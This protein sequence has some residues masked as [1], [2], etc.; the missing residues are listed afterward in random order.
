MENYQGSCKVQ[1]LGSYL[2]GG[3]VLFK[4]LFKTSV[5]QE[6]FWGPEDSKVVLLGPESLRMEGLTNPQ[7][8]QELLFLEY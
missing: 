4:D 5:L 6:A 7:L 2:A 3:L 8:T 1:Q